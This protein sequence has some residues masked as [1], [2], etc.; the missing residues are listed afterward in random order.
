MKR[1]LIVIAAAVCLVS[2]AATPARAARI[3]SKR[4][5][6]ADEVQSAKRHEEPATGSRLTSSQGRP[7]QK[8]LQ[9]TETARN[10]QA[11]IKVSF[12]GREFFL[13]K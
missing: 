4:D 6:D 3:P 5:G 1:F 11:H 9:E 13:E 10:R 2:T 8:R 12:P 7:T